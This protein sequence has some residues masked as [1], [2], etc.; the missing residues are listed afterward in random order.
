MYMRLN[1]FCVISER[2]ETAKT[3]VYTVRKFVDIELKLYRIDSHTPARVRLASICFK[4][5]LMTGFII[6]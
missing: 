3:E 1:T 6:D 5:R 2:I 4:I